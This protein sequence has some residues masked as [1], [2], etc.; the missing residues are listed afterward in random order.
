MPTRLLQK[1]KPGSYRVG[2][3]RAKFQ[4]AIVSKCASEKTAGPC[5]AECWLG[6]AK[7]R[8]VHLGRCY[9]SRRKGGQWGRGLCVRSNPNNLHSPAMVQYFTK[10]REPEEAPDRVGYCPWELYRQLGVAYAAS[11]GDSRHRTRKGR[12]AQEVGLPR[13][14][15]Q[16]SAGVPSTLEGLPGA[17]HSFPQPGPGPGLLKAGAPR[18]LLPSPVQASCTE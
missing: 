13:G 7:G 11:Q 1:E 3:G 12:L 2:S 17:L 16:C 10:A 15:A 6:W 8:L 18:S 4:K 14:R 5:S 9:N